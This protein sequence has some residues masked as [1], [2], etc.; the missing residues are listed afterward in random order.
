MKYST[1]YLIEKVFQ[2]FK[3]A[4]KAQYISFNPA[5]GIDIPKLEQVDRTP[6]PEE[7]IKGI[8]NFCNEYERGAM[9]M[10]L[11]YTGMRRG[12]MLAITVDDVDFD[13]GVIKVRKSVEFIKNSPNIKL[14]KTKKS[15]RNI[16][17][18]NPLL[19]YLKEV[20]QKKKKNDFVF[21]NK[22][23]E[24][25]GKTEIQRAM[26][27]F[28]KKYNMY[29]R[30]NDNVY[31]TA[32]QFRHTFATLLYNAGVDVK[33]AQEILGHSSVNITLDIYTH[34]DSKLKK[35]NTDKLNDYISKSSLAIV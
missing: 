29:L 17:I 22:K 2:I 6:I 25:Y 15:I 7:H 1:L 10:T 33:T 34:L 5:D 13:M 30:G 21:C 19:P 11:L 24:L 35:I 28:N 9:I 12:E 8:S 26:Q 3:Q 16:P 18:L 31:F 20:T 4:V 27:D 32:H 23:N 14:P